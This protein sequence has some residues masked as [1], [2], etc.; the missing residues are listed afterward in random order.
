M[1]RVAVSLVVY[2]V[3]GAR[4]TISTLRQRLSLRPHT[5]PAGFSPIRKGVRVGIL[6]A[7]VQAK[8]SRN[9]VVA[10]VANLNGG[11]PNSEDK[12]F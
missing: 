2:F 7:L 6:L 3:V 11:L 5:F 8:S 12:H 9:E 4:T 10:G 1:R